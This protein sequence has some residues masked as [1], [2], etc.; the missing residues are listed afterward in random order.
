MK[1]NQEV[2]EDF[3]ELVNMTASELEAWLKSKDSGEAGWSKDDESGETVGHESGRKITEI[4]KSN[5]N[6][7]PKKYNDDQI[8]H[9]RKVVAYCKRHLAQ[10]EQ[11]LKNKSESEAKK[12]KSYIS[13]KNWGHDPLKKGDD[14][15]KSNKESKGDDKEEPETKEEEEEETEAGDK[16][17]RK[18]KGA[19]PEP[20]KHR[21]RSSSKDAKPSSKEEEEEEEAADETE[22]DDEAQ[23]SNKSKSKSK[24]APKPGETVSW[25]WGNGQPKGKVLDVK[26][27]KATIT[28]KRGNKVSR[29]GDS[30]DPA[31]IL[32][33]GKSKAIKS[34]HE[35]N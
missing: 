32:D 23:E 26:E 29:D 22:S 2:I 24:N 21:T 1:D 28:T 7:D 9:M 35:L 25:N 10:E 19:A 12:T 17:K 14:N 31:V 34:A 6:K 13:L 3:N 15:K 8:S 16:R 5:P 4:L 11:S 30:E 18:D 27:D 20:K 33:T